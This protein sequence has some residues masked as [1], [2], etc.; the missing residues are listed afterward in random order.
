MKPMFAREAPPKYGKSAAA[1]PRARAR[2]TEEEFVEWY[3]KTDKS[4]RAEWVNGEVVMMSPDNLEHHDNEGLMY[5][6]LADFVTIKKLGRVF[7][8]RIQCRI[9]IRPSRR[10]PDIFFVSKD[11]L[12]I[13]QRTFIDGPPDF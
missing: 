12:H 13:L 7:H 11:R 2:M 6:V 10:E 4:V 8:S 1:K 9:P 3:W 5:R